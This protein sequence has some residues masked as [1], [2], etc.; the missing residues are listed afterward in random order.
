MSISRGPSRVAAARALCHAAPRA[1]PTRAPRHVETRLLKRLLS[2]S[3]VLN[4]HLFHRE[5]SNVV[6]AKIS[7]A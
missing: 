6:A 1:I 3:R 4:C 2:P 7:I 5:D